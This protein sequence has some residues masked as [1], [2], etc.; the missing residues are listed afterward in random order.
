MNCLYPLVFIHFVHLL[1]M[2]I[3]FP[4]SI[5][6][7][8]TRT[9]LVFAGKLIHFPVDFAEK[10]CRAVKTSNSDWCCCLTLHETTQILHW[11]RL[12]FGARCL[13]LCMICVD[14][15]KSSVAKNE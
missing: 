15:P 5:L 1:I 14:W 12:V 11:T 6:H 4:F 10:Y 2:H 3:G 9:P 7:H 13:G 8:I